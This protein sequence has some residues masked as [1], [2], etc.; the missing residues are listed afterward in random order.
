MHEYTPKHFKS[1]HKNKQKGL[2][3]W[4]GPGYKYIRPY[5]DPK[6]RNTLKQRAKDI[7]ENILKVLPGSFVKLKTPLSLKRGDGNLWLFKDG[8]LIND[9]KK[10]KIGEVY[11]FN[12]TSYTST[13]ISMY[14]PFDLDYA[15]KREDIL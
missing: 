14:A 10:L 9:I 12:E 15:K 6:K 4:T 7:D 8:K 11:N 3:N 1:F 13:S 2:L 5:L